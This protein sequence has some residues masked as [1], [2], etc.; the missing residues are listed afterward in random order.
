MRPRPLEWR[1]LLPVSNRAGTGTMAL[2][3]VAMTLLV[4]TG[5]VR[6]TR[7]LVHDGDSADQS[8]GWLSKVFAAT[9]VPTVA[10]WDFAIFSGTSNAGELQP[11]PFYPPAIVFGLLA[12]PG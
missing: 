6:G 11:A 3:A 12:H 4:F 10:L 7:T 5:V 9:H 1:R 2:V 8:F